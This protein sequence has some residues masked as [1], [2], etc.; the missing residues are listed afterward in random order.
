MGQD[1][2]DQGLTHQQARCQEQQFF[3]QEAPWATTFKKYEHRFGTLNL[4]GF[5]SGKLAE[6]IIKKLP[7]I[8][9]EINTRLHEVESALLQ[10]PEP[11]THNA[12]RIISDIILDFSQ[13]VRKELAAEFPYKVWRNNWK[14]LQKAFFDA[15][16][17]M[18]PTIAT[19]G[20]LDRNVY[21]EVLASQPGSSASKAIAVDDDEY[22]NDEN[23]GEESVELPETPTKKR[24]LGS[25]PVP[26]PVKT[27]SRRGLSKPLEEA[28][29]PSPD[30]SNLR[31]TFYLDEVK[32]YLAENS[33][34]KIPGQI[35]PRVVDTMMLETLAHWIQPLNLFFNTFEGQIRDQIKVLF[36][37]H[38]SKWAKSTF[39]V[40]AWK[41][42]E[43]M[44]NLNFHQQRTTMADES[45]NDE[46]EGPYIFHQDI[47]D[48]EK[49]N[50]LDNY[51]QARLRARLNVYKQ[52]RKRQ[53]GRAMTPTEEDKLKKDERAMLVL[54]RDPY[55]V[56]LGVVAQVTTYYM[57]A[58]RR[59][60]DA[61]CMRI[62]SKFYKQLRT[63]LRDEL[64]NGLGLND[65][66]EG[67]FQLCMQFAAYYHS[68]ICT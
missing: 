64:E 8:D 13:E 41:I 37:K 60:H 7:I 12:S 51:H 15:L 44:L 67:M 23:N 34:S 61:I 32:R 4:Q 38:F 33:Q 14:A 43:Q 18:K 10:F 45:L 2:I 68:L 54:N 39:H 58:V 16:V 29:I 66:D 56:E 65:G 48:A 21:A 40:S 3:S 63:Q 11:P 1:Q 36:D 20:S 57:L 5:L 42:V 22:E 35:E 26:S 28:R 30:F 31:K 9:N 49:A 6:Q 25:I 27:P 59:F 46:R 62:E 47:F 52:A 17:S 55:D 24:K 19:N 50:V 53:T